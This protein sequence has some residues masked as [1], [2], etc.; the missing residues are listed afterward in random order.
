M[1][2]I[3]FS[4]LLLIQSIISYAQ[5]PNLAKF[6]KVE[7][8]PS[9]YH[10]PTIPISSLVT[11]TNQIWVVYSDKAENSIYSDKLS[12]KI[13][14]QV[15]FL[16]SFFVIS[17]AGDMFELVKYNYSLIS[18]TGKIVSP[19]KIEYV[20]WINKSNLLLNERCFL[21]S[22]SL[23][24]YKYVTILNGTN[25][26]PTI[27]SSMENNDIKVYSNPAFKNNQLVTTIN[28]NEVVYVYKFEKDK[29]LIGKNT[30]FNTKN[31]S[32]NILGWVSIDFIKNWGTRLNIEVLKPENTDT[33]YS[34]LFPTKNL[35][36]NF[37]SNAQIAM[38]LLTNT[39]SINNPF[40]NKHPVYNVELT[41][42]NNV[43][44]K[45]IETGT[46]LSP[47]D[48][49]SAYIYSLSGSK[50]D[51]STFCNLSENS[52]NTNI[53]FALNI[54]NDVKEYYT[55]LIETF[56]DLDTYFSTPKAG[57]FTFSF[58]NTADNSFTQVVTKD[59]YYELLPILINEIK[60]HVQFKK[61]ASA[62]GI[63]N[64][65]SS[66]SNFFSN[67]S[68]ENNILL[69][70]STQ[71]DYAAG[72]NIYKTK[73]DKITN[74]IANTHSRVIMYQP[75][76]SSG[77]GYS[78]FITQSKIILKRYADKSIQYTKSQL[79]THNENADQNN[80]KS[81]ETG[82]SNMYCL[83]YPENANTQGFITFPT[84]GSK[85]DKK[86]AA[87]TIDSLLNQ[88]RFETTSIQENINKTFNS[89]SVFNTKRNIYFEKYYN[90]YS[91]VPRNLELE[92]K[93]INFNYFIKGYSIEPYNP[94]STKRNYQQTLLL[95]QKEYDEL[96]D[97]FKYLKL[98]Q[99]LLNPNE[100]NKA[101]T[102]NAMI[103]LFNARIEI[104]KNSYNNPSLKNF[105]FELSGYTSY[106]KS[107][108]NFN[109]SNLFSNPSISKEDTYQMLSN[110]KKSFDSYYE[111]KN[112]PNVQF[113]SNGILYYWVN[114]N[115]LP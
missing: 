63:L 114:E 76:A 85:I 115:R 100:I 84:A 64:G 59:N 94:H 58:I 26:F 29:V 7:L 60:E 113:Q 72:D 90:M 111:L 33:I 2:K 6:K 44:Y 98:D 89:S 82:V 101:Y 5:L 31:G 112:N 81:L 14:S 86:N 92:C 40:L 106:S 95:N 96:A 39:C 88:I 71:G 21:E 49:S 4:I 68:G 107:F 62:Y 15:A 28:F 48:N 54:D 73:F 46:I 42:K 43:A 69:M 47:F 75:Y 77:V 99:L 56:Q 51:Y 97:F 66:A 22:K 10:Y 3:L 24:A 103:A 78:N 27:I 38:P 53:V 65:L 13:T 67:H 91:T 1:Y 79:I 109:L 93:N 16:D 20:G 50:I 57:A 35:A 30:Q 23:N 83:D 34:Y 52:K 11:K 37:E 25:I 55:G 8:L 80:F 9:N 41:N 70:I 17:V 36:I 87:R 19:D 18:I 102:Q 105:F 104:S 45:T 74:D 32:K 108:D 61:A 110:L 12:T